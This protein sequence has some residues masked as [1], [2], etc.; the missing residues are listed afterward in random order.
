MTLLLKY[1]L[2]FVF[3]KNKRRICVHR[4]FNYSKIL[5]I[6]RAILLQFLLKTSKISIKVTSTSFL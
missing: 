4:R 5:S 6:H 2:V 3:N 1:S